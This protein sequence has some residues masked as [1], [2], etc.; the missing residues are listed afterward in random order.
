MILHRFSGALHKQDWVTVVIE[1]L[2]VVF[3]VFIGLQV[4]N[5]N[6][7]RELTKRG[8]ALEAQLVADVRLIIEETRGNFA[9]IEQS[10]ADVEWL[11]QA[12]SQTDVAITEAEFEEHANILSLPQPAKRSPAFIEALSGGGLGL[13]RDTNLRTA[14]VKRDRL[15]QDSAETQQ[16][17]REFTRSYVGPVVRLGTALNP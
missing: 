8:I 2:I 6:E 7:N 13:I 17:V 12:F 14:L 9:H 1:T 16:A 11:K 3:G 5:W 4:N 15:L 10:L